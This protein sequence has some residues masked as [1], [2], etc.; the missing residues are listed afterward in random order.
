MKMKDS[1]DTEVFIHKLDKLAMRMNEDFCMSIGDD[2]LISKVLNSFP[3]SY[4][5]LVYSIHIEMNS[6]T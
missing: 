4:E 1:E 3:E 6:K 5:P 2:Y